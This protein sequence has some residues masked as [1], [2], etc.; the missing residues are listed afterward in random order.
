MTKWLSSRNKGIAFA[1]VLL[2]IIAGIAYFTWPKRPNDQSGDGVACTQ[3]ARLCPD[4]SYV[5]RTG[6]NC[7]FAACPGASSTANDLWQTITDASSG[8]TFSYPTT[9]TTH[10][11][12]PVDWPPKVAVFDKSFSCTQADDEY[13]QAGRTIRRMVDNR[14]YCVTMESNVGAGSV[15]TQYAYAVEK[16]GKSL[17]FT[18]SLQAGAC[19]HYDEP[20]RTEC[21]NER[22]TFD[23]DGVVDRI[24]QSVTLPQ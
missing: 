18:F 19:D 8:V 13:S 11:T 24:A 3:E 23:L 5:G 16:N 6:P 1:V 22:E 15:L 17:I 7:E 9:L 21:N 12:T 4:G 2:I 10:Y 20:Q 14:T